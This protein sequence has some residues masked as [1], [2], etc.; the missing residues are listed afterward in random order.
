MSDGLLEAE[1]SIKV[2]SKPKP[3]SW[4]G[5]SLSDVDA[6][7]SRRWRTG[8]C[9]VEGVQFKAERYTRSMLSNSRCS[10]DKTDFSYCL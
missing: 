6:V 8:K 3:F 10:G 9:D 1:I 5:V 4:F 7:W 2:M